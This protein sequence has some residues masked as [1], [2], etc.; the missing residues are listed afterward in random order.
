[1]SP[2]GKSPVI[3]CRLAYSAKALLLSADVTVSK[4]E[5]ASDKLV[6]WLDARPECRDLYDSQVLC[7]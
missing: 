4:E 3:V 2:A 1:M 5:G 7:P 6:L